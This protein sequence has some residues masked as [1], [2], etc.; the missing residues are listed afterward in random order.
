V[1]KNSECLEK[2]VVLGLGRGVIFGNMPGGSK[3][4]RGLGGE[5][6]RRLLR[7]KRE[8]RPGDEVRSGKTRLSAPVSLAEGPFGQHASLKPNKAAEGRAPKLAEPHGETVDRE[9]R[10]SAS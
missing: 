4:K 9:I 6:R 5:P 10:R 2:G 8:M 1:G 3:I 7:K